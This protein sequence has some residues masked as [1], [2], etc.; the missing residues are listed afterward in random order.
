MESQEWELQRAKG[1]AHLHRSEANGLQNELKALSEQLGALR[2]ENQRLEALLT[3]AESSLSQASVTEW[4]AERLQLKGKLTEA[5]EERERLEQELQRA[6][7]MQPELETSERERNEAVEEAKALQTEIV[8]LKESL[9]GA[10]RERESSASGHVEKIQAMSAEIKARVAET[11]HLK[12]RVTELSAQAEEVSQMRTTLV[13]REKSA[14]A[15]AF[16][17][18][19]AESQEKVTALQAELTSL[20]L[21]VGPGL[22][23]LKA[24]NSQLRRE[25]DALEA[26]LL[27]GEAEHRSQLLKEGFIPS[28]EA[29]KYRTEIRDL[30]ETEASLREEIRESK[31]PGNPNPRRMNLPIKF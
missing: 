6:L 20:R 29:V 11:T 26:K 2:N 31:H 8:R 23:D 1:D 18:G 9:A 28:A 15:A 22:S 7:L 4:T 10:K 27:I 3:G 13:N 16:I 17:K 30:R 21:N 25:K 14:V 12:L 19:K 24:E 5:S